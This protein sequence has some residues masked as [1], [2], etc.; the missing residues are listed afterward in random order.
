LLTAF[1]LQVEQSESYEVQVCQRH[2][3]SD[4]ANRFEI[5]AFTKPLKQRLIVRLITLGR[6][7]LGS[8]THQEVSHMTG[9][10][11]WMETHDQVD[12]PKA[13][14]MEVRNAVIRVKIDGNRWKLFAVIDPD[15]NF[16]QG[17]DILQVVLLIY[18]VRFTLRHL[19]GHI[20]TRFH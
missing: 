10:G 7:P 19:C 15:S 18:L 13:A 8:D 16:R 17:W 6:M 1:G 11:T 9:Y 5:D 12:V 3:Q 2:E 14:R 20:G 4:M